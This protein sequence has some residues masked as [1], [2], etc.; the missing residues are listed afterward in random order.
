MATAP[1]SN[2]AVELIPLAQA[3]RAALD[4]LFDQQV[5]EWLP[6]L[7]WD[8]SGP[9][10]MI[11]DVAY[12]RLLIGY[13]AK[14]NGVVAGFAFYVVEGTR[15]SIGDIY[16]SPASRGRGVDREMVAAILNDIE[17][18]PR[19]IRIESQ[20]V[21]VDNDGADEIFRARG[22]HR[23]ERAYMTAPLAALSQEGFQRVHSPRRSGEL[24][25]ITVRRWNEEDFS[26]AARIIHRSYRGES[27]SRIN[28]QYRTEAGCGELL[29]IL[30]DSGWCGR[31]LPDVSCVAEDQAAGQKIGV[32]IASMI[33]PGSGH[34]AQISV[35]PGYQGHGV[36]R[37]MIRSALIASV[38]RG[39][40]IVSLAV[41]E[42][43]LPAVHL[44]LS[45]GFEPIHRFAVHYREARGRDRRSL[46]HHE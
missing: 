15:A 14:L 19:V 40:D 20:C 24:L 21:T 7:H 45:C 22:F 34:L 8:Y 12:R 4:S 32:L 1:L 31:F 26:D 33:A 25:D 43:N 30:T 44:Y 35:V 9:S 13:A 10:R 38:R 46:L 27:D 3:D 42:T 29:S 17:R 28:A 5:E 37:R 6:L 2:N 16:V 39:F 11:R 36:G 23:F 41:T 18:L